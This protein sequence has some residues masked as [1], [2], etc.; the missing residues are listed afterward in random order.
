[1][2]YVFLLQDM[3]PESLEENTDVIIHFYKKLLYNKQPNRLQN[4]QIMCPPVL[5][6][7]CFNHRFS[8][9]YVQIQH[10]VSPFDFQLLFRGLVLGDVMTA[11]LQAC[12]VLFCFFFTVRIFSPHLLTSENGLQVFSFVCGFRKEGL[13]LSYLLLLFLSFGF[14]LHLTFKSLE[15]FYFDH[16]SLTY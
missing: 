10:P 7:F 2:K 12:G 1:M 11:H 6:V 15:Y 5:S 14:C 4:F 8:V 3:S 16:F 9:L 13:E